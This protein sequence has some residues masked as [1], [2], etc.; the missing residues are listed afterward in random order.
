VRIRDGGT[1][2]TLEELRDAAA[3]AGLGRQKWP[4]LVRVVD[5]FPRTPF[6]KIKKRD[7]RDLMR[8]ATVA[9]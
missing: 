3:A 5:D 8:D 1:G 4:E 7:L 9:G 6:G 2:P